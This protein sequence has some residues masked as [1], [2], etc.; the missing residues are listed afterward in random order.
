[1]QVYK[2]HMLRKYKTNPTT[3]HVDATGSVVRHVRGKTVYCYAV[4]AEA[5]SGTY[6]LGLML[7]NSNSTS[8]ITYFLTRLCEAFK[9]VHSLQMSQPVVVCDFSWAL[10]HSAL[11]A[12]NKTGIREYLGEAWRR[13]TSQNDVMQGSQPTQVL[14]CTAHVAHNFARI[15]KE[16]VREKVVRAAYMWLLTRLMG[17]EQLTDIAEHFTKICTLAL[18]HQ[19]IDYVEESLESAELPETE[20]THP[21]PAGKTSLRTAT[22]FG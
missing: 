12:F 8:T 13:L 20:A 17:C 3:L 18:A 16:H 10:L 21:L 1:M 9:T 4:V 11:A 14:M 22:P 7:S 19:G 5:E 2:E 6:P 15:L